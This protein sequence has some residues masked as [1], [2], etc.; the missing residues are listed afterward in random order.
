MNAPQ[1]TII[2]S[3]SLSLADDENSTPIPPSGFWA[4]PRIMYALALRKPSLFLS[5][6]LCEIVHCLNGALI[7]CWARSPLVRVDANSNSNSNPFNESTP[8]ALPPNVSTGP[9]PYTLLRFLDISISLHN[10]PLTD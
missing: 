9:V 10:H 4:R 2:L 5:L 1:L 8:V 7:A 6:S 3:L